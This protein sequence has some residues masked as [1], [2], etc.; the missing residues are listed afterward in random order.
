MSKK[1]R[2]VVFLAGAMFILTSMGLGNAAMA[3]K[4]VTMW[5]FPMHG[6]TE[7]MQNIFGPVLEDF[8]QKEP[9]I[10]VD[11]Q[12]FPWS[13]RRE[14]MLT[15]IAAGMS[16]DVAYLNGDMRAMFEDN[17]VYLEKYISKED[18]KDFKQSAIEG[19]SY[20]G[21]LMFLPMLQNVEAPIYNLDYLE[22]AGIGSEWVDSLH[23]WEEFFEVL[24][25]IQA[26]RKWAYT[27]GIATAGVIDDWNN[28]LSQAGGEYYNEEKTK[29]LL[30]S[31]EAVE[32]MEAYVY[33]YDNFVN[34]A[35]RAKTPQ[36]A[37]ESFIQGNVAVALVQN[38]WISTVREANPDI[39]VAYGYPLEK[40]K[41]VSEGTIAGYG[42]FKQTD[43]NPE[44]AV[45]WIKE[46]TG[47]KGMFLMTT[48][49]QFIP[50]RYSI[51]EKVAREID[52]AVY[53][54]AVENSEW[55]EGYP[56]SPIGAA[57]FEEIKVAI[58]E[59]VLHIKSPKEAISDATKRINEL[60]VDYYKKH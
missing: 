42:V 21:H 44:A 36:E 11:I 47:P 41:R 12:F 23:T 49:I 52:D 35:D 1:D 15:A 28:W 17:L 50:P 56:I 24:R 20:K 34:P 51:G 45:K 9:N 3:K 46:L 59:A 48:T 2:M 54:R 14:R 31:P 43:D 30:D 38:Q 27:S 32:A 16:P 22:E 6:E 33:I 58:Q 18:L 39:K 4:E 8:A 57:A 19:S 13:A 37:N 26:T 5:V 40:R 10:K 53:N 60:L 25:K 7:D 55:F 29:C